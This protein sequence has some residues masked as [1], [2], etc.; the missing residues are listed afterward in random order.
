[1]NGPFTMPH[2]IT[3]PELIKIGVL[4]IAVVSWGFSLDNRVSLAEMAMQQ[5]SIGYRYIQA[6]LS[7]QL[8]R[9]DAR[10]ARIEDI[11]LDRHTH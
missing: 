8:S 10:L 11:L 3:V 9:V 6:E 7:K 2:W 5:E 1:M 4:I